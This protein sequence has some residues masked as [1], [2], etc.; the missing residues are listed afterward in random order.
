MI[1]RKHAAFALIRLMP[2]LFPADPATS[3]PPMEEAEVVDVIRG[4]LE[5]LFPKTCPNCGETFATFRD[6]LLGTKYQGAPISYDV[7][8]GFW[9][10]MEPLGAVSMANC[11]C[12]NTLALTSA[13][14]PLLQ[15]WRLL[16]WAKTE[17]EHQGLSQ[18][19]LLSHVRT[20]VRRRVLAQPSPK[21]D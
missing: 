18:Q 14:M 10:P 19:E 4:H 6:Y 12:G 17:M 3:L 15:L 16:H 8:L 9:N 21:K 5:G 20:E 7:E 11:S 1:D 13:G 2:P